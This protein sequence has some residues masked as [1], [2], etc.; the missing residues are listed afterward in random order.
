MYIAPRNHFILTKGSI[1]IMTRSQSM[2]RFSLGVVSLLA[3]A[4]PLIM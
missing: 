2:Y 3:I 4:L 1:Y